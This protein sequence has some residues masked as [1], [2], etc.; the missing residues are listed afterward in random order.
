MSVINVVPTRPRESNLFDVLRIIAAAMVIVGH[1]WPL[2]STSGVPTFAGIRIHHLGVYIFFAISGYLL[3]TSW[4]RQPEALPFL[5]RRCLR[6]FPALIVTVIATVFVIGPIATTLTAGTYFSSA[7]TWRYLLSAILLAQYE[8]PGVFTTHPETAVNGS[9][10]SLGVEF[11]CYLGIVLVS[12]F[13]RRVRVI[14]GSLLIVLIG[15]AL[16]T[17]FYT[18]PMRTTAI[19]VAF[20]AMGA[21]LSRGAHLARWPVWPALVALIL[22]AP[23]DGWVGELLALPVVAYAVIAIGSRKSRVA[24]AVRKAGDPSY[25]MYLWGFPIQQLLIQ[26]TGTTSVALSIAVVL[27]LAAGMGY[28][29]WWLVEQPSIRFGAKL[30]RL[31]SRAVREDRV[32]Q[33]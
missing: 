6:I 32:V 4:T 2:T 27:P 28:L 26:A 17:D 12:L 21:V 22:I 29:S 18:G 1:A 24:S 8:L 14:A 5:I 19:A 20:F 23:T 13:G 16:I 3:A 15:A 7:E 11:S 25:G 31:A 30:S 33:S 10:W 9:L